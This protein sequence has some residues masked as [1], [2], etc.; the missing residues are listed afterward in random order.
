MNPPDVPTVTA[1]RVPVPTPPGVLVLD[2]RED[3]EWQAG[4]IEGAV[5]IPLSQLPER[6]SEISSGEEFRQVLAVCRSGGRSARA[7]MFLRQ[8]GHDAVNLDRGMHGW[9]EAG[10]PMVSDTGRAPEVA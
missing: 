9:S 6:S 3:D 4:H 2:V 8:Q 1:D 7:T 5:H 10:H